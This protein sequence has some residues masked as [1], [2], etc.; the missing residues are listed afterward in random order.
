MITKHIPK[1]VLISLPVEDLQALII[2][3]V[4][5]CL[6]HR[7]LLVNEQEEILEVDAV[8]RMF[9]VSRTTVYEWRRSG[10]VPSYHRGRR[11]YFKKSELLRFRKD[12][13]EAQEKGGEL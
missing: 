10:K 8:C 5:A 13:T 11:V 4:N 12:E 1:T 7:S 3:S 2:D 9:G 6:K